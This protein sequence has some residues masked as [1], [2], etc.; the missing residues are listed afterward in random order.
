MSPVRRLFQVYAWPHRWSFL[1]GAFCLGLTNYL[2]V[3]IP[4]QIG[5]AIDHLSDGTA[6]GYVTAIAWMGV[7]IMVVRTL[8]RVLFFNPGRDIE[9]GIRRDLFSHLLALQPSFYATHNRGDIISR[10]SNDI[11]WTRVMVGFGGL[12]L[13]N[14]GFAL[15]FTCW[16]MFEISAFLSFAALSPIFLGFVIVNVVIRRLY[17]LMKRNQEELARISEHVLESF[18]GVATIQGFVAE[19]AFHKEFAERNGQWFRTGLRLAVYRSIFA[20]LIALSAGGSVASLIYFGGPMAVRGELS[21]GDL[22]AFVALIATLVPY[23]RSIGWMLSVWQRGMA[24]LDRIFELIDAPVERTEGDEPL[25]MQSGKGPGIDFS[26]LRFAYPDEPEKDVLHDIDLHVPPGST[27]GVFG[28][29]GSGKSTLLQLLSRTHAPAE[30]ML[31]IDGADIRDLDIFEWRKRLSTVPQR[32]FLFSES[33][34]ANIS[35][36]D[37]LPHSQLED[38]VALA[39]LGQDLPALP[40]G[41]DTVVGE[42]GIM[43]SGGQRQRVALARGL[44]QK[45]DLILLDDVLSAVDHEN[46]ARLVETLSGLSRGERRLTCFIVS[47]RISAFRYADFIMVLE[48]GRMVRCASHSEL[49]GEEGIYR[50]SYLAQR[51]LA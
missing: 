5:L 13:V 45:G 30:G 2:T 23:M 19:E 7:A 6:L 38:V 46:E 31:S 36:Q 44:Y 20:P 47:N 48:E 41:L 37:G 17:P 42:R 40:N 35:L 16:K 8:S 34:A 25:A 26:G 4:E 1:G 51:E 50:D 11:S 15:S 33:I 21:I 39:S 27:V 43:L 28:R 10:A 14:V 18:Q 3:S 9:H 49:I 22:A 12:Q 24:S 29:T 32:P